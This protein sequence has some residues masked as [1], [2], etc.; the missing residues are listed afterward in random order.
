M[1]YGTAAA[2]VFPR[3]VTSLVTSLT[4]SSSLITETPRS[5]GYG[6]AVDHGC[7][8]PIMSYMAFAMIGIYTAINVNNV[9]RLNLIVCS[10]DF[11]FSH[12]LGVYCKSVCVA[13][14]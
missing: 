10:T 11:P 2:T 9:S 4:Y 3:N 14:S 13:S 5:K 12:D 8:L 6:N 7:S 1:E